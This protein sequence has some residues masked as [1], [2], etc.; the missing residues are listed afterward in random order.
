MLANKTTVEHDQYSLEAYVQYATHDTSTTDTK[1]VP[2]LFAVWAQI[3]E[4]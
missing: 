4:T 3:V 2:D 1:T